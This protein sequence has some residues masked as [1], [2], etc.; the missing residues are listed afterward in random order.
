MAVFFTAD[1]HFGH[2]AI[3]KHGKRPFR[4]VEEMDAALIERWNARVGAEDRIYHLGDFCFKGS[5]VAQSYLDKLQGEIILIRGNHD[6]ENT[7]K[8]ERFSAAHDLHSFSIKGQEI[9]LCHYPLLEWP[10]AYKG[11][12]HLHGHTHGRVPPNRKRCDVG[13]DVWDFTPITLDEIRERLTTAPD[14]DPKD[15]YQPR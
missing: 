14:Y 2:G 7:A 8:L 3:I 4:S 15:A 10:G 9:I 13:S 1:T 6:T 12:I 5:K 11:A